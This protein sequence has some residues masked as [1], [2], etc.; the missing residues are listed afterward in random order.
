MKKNSKLLLVVIIVVAILVFKPQTQF[1]SISGWEDTKTECEIELY[2]DCDTNDYNTECFKLTSSMFNQCDPNDELF[3]SHYIGK[4]VYFAYDSDDIDEYGQDAL[5]CFKN[6]GIDIDAGCPDRPYQYCWDSTRFDTSCFECS[7]GGFNTFSECEN[8][9]KDEMKGWC[10]NR[11]SFPYYWCSGVLGT[12]GQILYK[13]I[14]SSVYNSELCSGDC[15]YSSI[16]GHYSC[17][18]QDTKW[19]KNSQTGGCT[20][21]TCS[22][23][24]DCAT[25]CTSGHIFTTQS[26]CQSACIYSSVC[27]EQDTCG[28][29]RPGGTTDGNTCGLNQ[30]CKNG[31]CTGVVCNVD[32]ECQDK[33]DSKLYGCSDHLCVVKYNCVT[34]SDCINVYGEN[35][36]CDSGTC[37]IEIEE[38]TDCVPEGGIQYKVVGGWFTN[39]VAQFPDWNIGKS[40]CSGLSEQR[41]ENKDI[42]TTFTTF[43]VKGE[44]YECSKSTGCPSFVKF[45]SFGQDFFGGECGTGMI[46][47][48]IFLVIFMNLI[49]KK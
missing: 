47:M 39:I 16:D 24:Q 43:L 1:Q 4:Y 41:R 33:Y 21:I 30:V 13:C 2:D 40:C 10:E 9:R 28:N 23:T 19:C 11:G 37:K 46:F 38:P 27:D 12:Q 26:A 36:N 14:S 17:N 31:V 35:Y 6:K 42:S 5:N 32:K 8:F 48:V 45:F 3:E 49:P 15:G 34:D 20:E 22:G 18:M 7:S 29:P 44:A 25:K